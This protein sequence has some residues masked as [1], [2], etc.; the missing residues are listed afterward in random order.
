MRPDTR[1][2]WVNGF[3]QKIPERKGPKQKVFLFAFLAIFC[4]NSFFRKRLNQ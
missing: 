3:E 4:S 2:V 1:K